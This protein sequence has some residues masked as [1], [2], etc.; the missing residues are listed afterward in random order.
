MDSKKGLTDETKRAIQLSWPYLLIIG[1]VLLFFIYFL[2][3]I[4][5]ISPGWSYIIQKF[6]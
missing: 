2:F 6:I 4:S 5:F 3:H 1:A